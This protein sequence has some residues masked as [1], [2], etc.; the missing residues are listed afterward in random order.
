MQFVGW[1]QHEDVLRA[2]LPGLV[3][4]GSV[5]LPEVLFVLGTSLGTFR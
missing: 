2:I 4:G 3:L 1:N 5:S